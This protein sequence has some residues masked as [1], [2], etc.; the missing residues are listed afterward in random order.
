MPSSCSSP[1]TS[2]TSLTFREAHGC[3]T[4]PA[5]VRGSLLE[6]TWLEFEWLS[7]REHEALA[8][9][10]HEV[11]M[12]QDL[13]QREHAA[14]LRVLRGVRSCLSGGVYLNAHDSEG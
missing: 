2:P 10:I 12:L 9:E 6:Q 8:A 5:E 11:Q 7:V 13:L 4:A 14:H 3:S 1:A